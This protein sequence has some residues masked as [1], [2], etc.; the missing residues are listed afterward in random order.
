M[1]FGNSFV[2]RIPRWRRRR[3]SKLKFFKINTSEPCY[4]GPRES[5]A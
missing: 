3:W 2:L 5:A 1:S 4:F